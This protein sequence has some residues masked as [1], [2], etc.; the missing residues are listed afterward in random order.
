MLINNLS[1]AC[2]EV[3]LKYFAVLEHPAVLVYMMFSALRNQGFGAAKEDRLKIR[4]FAV[5]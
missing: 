4:L 5:P 2:Q 3:D 1:D